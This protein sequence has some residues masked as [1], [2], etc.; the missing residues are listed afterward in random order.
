MKRSV[1][2]HVVTRL[3]RPPEV[4]LLEKNYSKPVDIWSCGVILAEMFKM[5][6]E[7]NLKRKNLFWGTG[8]FPLSP[9]K[10]TQAFYDK[11]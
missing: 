11:P 10:K 5:N 4:I 6:P 3:Y 9:K 7:N 8:C 1:S 2:P